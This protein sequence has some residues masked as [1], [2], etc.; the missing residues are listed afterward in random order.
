[1]HLAPR[2]I[3]VDLEVMVIKGYSALLPSLKNNFIAYRPSKVSD[4]IFEIHQLWQSG[5]SRVRS[6]CCCSCWFEP[7]IIKIGQSS[8]QMYINNIL[9]FQGFSLESEKSWNAPGKIGFNSKQT[10]IYSR[11]FD[12]LITICYKHFYNKKKKTKQN[13]TKPQIKLKHKITA[14]KN[15]KN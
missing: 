10:I 15:P 9:N 14:K 1:M 12:S 4:C 5:F 11:S 8:H 6:N 13:K 3:L 7:E 2:Q